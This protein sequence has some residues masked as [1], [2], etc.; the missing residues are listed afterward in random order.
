LKGYRVIRWGDNKMACIVV[1]DMD[2]KLLLELLSGVLAS[3][4]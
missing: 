3:S 4:A 2:E 1:S